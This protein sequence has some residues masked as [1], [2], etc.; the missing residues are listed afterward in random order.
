M[1][2]PTL[3]SY[4]ERMAASLG[5]KMKVLPYVTGTS[6]LDVGCGSGDLMHALNDAGY[7]TCGIDASPESVERTGSDCV[8][9]GYANEVGWRFGPESFDTVICS[10]VFHEVFSYG[11]S[12]GKVGR[13]SSLSDALMSIHDVLKPGGR[14]IVRDGVRPSLAGRPLMWVDK[15]EEVEKFL[16]ASPFAR[17]H[18]DRSIS[19]D[20]VWDRGDNWFQGTASSLMEF[21]FT[22][23]WGPAAFEREVQEFYGIFSLDQYSWFVRNHGFTKIDAFEYTQPG[24]AE[25]LKGKVNMLMPFPS[26]NAIWVYEKDKNA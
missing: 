25:H 20:R 12:D 11:N 5:D 14:L 24:Y 22:Y 4:Y 17:Q 7:M 18:L 1:V 8:Q 13:I 23:T 3:D 19:L 26:T 6:V 2:T 21:A 9:V 15:P 10:S 16:A